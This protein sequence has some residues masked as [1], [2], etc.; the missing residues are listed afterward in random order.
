MKILYSL[1]IIIMRKKRIHEFCKI[2]EMPNVQGSVIYLINHSCKYDY[3]YI[4][5]IIGKQSYVL[6]GKQSLEIIDRICFF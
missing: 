5:E 1:L 2:R 6:V 3:P 4:S